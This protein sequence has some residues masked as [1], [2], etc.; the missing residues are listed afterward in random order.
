[1][2]S[3]SHAAKAQLTDV[4]IGIA[5][6]FILHRLPDYVDLRNCFTVLSRSAKISVTAMST[7][8]L[9]TLYIAIDCWL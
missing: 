6:L 5:K 3:P 2:R 4:D 7:K 9:D 1:L 8:V